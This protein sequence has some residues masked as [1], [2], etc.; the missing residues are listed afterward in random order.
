MVYR[1]YVEK[2]EEFASEAFSLKNEIINLLQIKG[3]K[4]LRIVNRYDV[5]NI[6]EELFESSVTR[7]FSEPQVDISSKTL[8]FDRGETY[9]Y[10][11]F[12]IC[13]FCFNQSLFHKINVF[14]HQYQIQS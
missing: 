10:F 1:I 2:K 3:L 4:A 8:R 6:S 11:H 12:F 13:L 14:I 9:R 7:V 5:E